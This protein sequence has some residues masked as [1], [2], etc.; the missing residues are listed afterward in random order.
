MSGHRSFVLPGLQRS[1]PGH[2]NNDSHL[3]IEEVTD[4]EWLADE[5][6]VIIKMERTAV[7]ASTQVMSEE[8]MAAVC[9]AVRGHSL[10]LSNTESRA[11]ALH[12]PQALPPAPAGSARV[13]CESAS[14]R[15]LHGDKAPVS[16][17][18]LS[19]FCPI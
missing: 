10:A 5:R 3:Y 13:T 14:K 18:S 7:P 6:E 15:K 8:R 1:Q 16:G 17:I 11:A 12:L 9:R 19:L 4:E 2:S